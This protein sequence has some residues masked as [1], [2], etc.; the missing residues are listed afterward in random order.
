MAAPQGNK[1][2][3]K[4]K[5]WEGALRAALAQFEDKDKKI[6]PGQALRKIAEKVVVRAIEGDKDAIKE[7]G[8][9]LDGK[10][11]Q[12]VTI[13][14]DSEGDPIKTEMTVKLVKSDAG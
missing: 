2:A 9:R 6:E 7:I 1:N 8:D 4:A 5:V 13:A 3:A 12:A 10:A 14:G 11:A